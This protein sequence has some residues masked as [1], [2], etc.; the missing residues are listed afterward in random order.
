MKAVILPILEANMTQGIIRAWLKREGEMVQAGDPLFEVETD[1]V[2]AEVEAEVSGVLRHIAVPVGARAPVLSVLAFIGAADEAIPAPET[3]SSLVPPNPVLEGTVDKGERR[4]S[5]ASSFDKLRRAVVDPF[6]KD[7]SAHPEALEACPEPRRRGCVPRKSTVSGQQDLPAVAVE[8]SAPAAAATAAPSAV[9]ASEARVAASPAARQF[10]R[11]RGIA[12]E[13]IRPTGTRGEITRGDVEAAIAS[14]TV[15]SG[16]GA[17]DPSFLTLLRKDGGAIRQLS[18]EMKVRLYRE[19]GAYIGEG[20]RIESGAL[21]IAPIVRIGAM[22]TIGADSTIECD[23]LQLG[24]LVAFGKRTRVRCRSAEIGDALWSKDDVI[25]GGGGSE[26]PGARLRAGDACFFGESA[27]LNTCHPLTLGNEVCIGSRAMLFTHSHWQSVLRGY[28]S[29]F[30]PI[31]VGD[32]VFIGNN[33]FVFPGVTIGSGATVM[34]NSFVGINVPPDTFV[35]GVPAQV[36]RH[37]TRPTRDQQIALVR[38]RLMPEIGAALA[39][40]GYQ[41]VR[42]GD[43]DPSTLDL[44][45]GATVQF[46]ATLQPADIPRGGRAVILTFADDA[47]PAVPPGVTLLDLEGYRIFG[48]QDALSDTIREFC[49]RR[50]IRFRPFAWRYRVGH[51]EGENFRPYTD[52]RQ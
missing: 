1:K 39:A 49:R 37:I 36:I 32:H 22:S 33:A 23:R 2:N 38:D 24:R 21:M 40:S 30:G 13:K 15:T 17:L 6:Q 46:V 31:Q 51:F 16:D 25:I 9:V 41:V 35:G 47:V 44:G 50:G 8:S 26:E 42:R 19:H 7:F 4:A 52:H 3:W 43:G 34:V 18:S 14:V 27:Y 5:R 11:E 28:A 45:K 29:M 20:V 10:A 48:V 12:L